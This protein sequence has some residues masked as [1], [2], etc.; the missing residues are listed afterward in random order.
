V[1]VVVVVQVYACRQ[2]APGHPEDHTLSTVHQI[3][4]AWLMVAQG[5]LQVVEERVKAGDPVGAAKKCWL[6]ERVWKLLLATMDLLQVMDPNDFMRL[7]HEL[8]INTKSEGGV[9]YRSEHV[10]GGGF[11]NCCLCLFCLTFSVAY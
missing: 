5:L 11:R 9:D 3:L 8:A 6:V 4:E 2:G 10:G 7:K 1:V